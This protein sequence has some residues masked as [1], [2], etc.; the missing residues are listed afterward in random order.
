[1]ETPLTTLHQ[2]RDKSL[3][4]KRRRH[5]WDKA[6]TTKSLRMYDARVV[7]YADTLIKQMRLRAG[8][9][10]NVTKWFNYYSFDVMGLSPFSFLHR[11]SKANEHW[12]VISHLDAPLQH[13]RRVK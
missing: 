3:H 8:Q 4:D 12:Q 13:L 11:V 10:V 5:G 9:E 7:G 2:M 1:M 6:F